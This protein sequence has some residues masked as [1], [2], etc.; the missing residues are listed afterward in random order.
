MPRS[1]NISHVCFKNYYY[2]I[3]YNLYNYPI[4]YNYYYGIL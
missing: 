2:N 1:S 4:I 3:L